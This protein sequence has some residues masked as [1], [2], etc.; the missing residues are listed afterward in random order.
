VTVVLGN[1]GTGSPT[2]FAVGLGIDGD[3]GAGKKPVTGPVEP[4]KEVVVVF[5]NIRLRAGERQLTAIVDVNKTIDEPREDNNELKV[6]VR[7]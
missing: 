3:G 6:A 5:E 2:G 4:G 7:C 1:Q